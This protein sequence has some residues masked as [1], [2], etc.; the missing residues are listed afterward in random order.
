MRKALSSLPRALGRR[1]RTLNTGDARGQSLVELALTIPIILMLTLIALD[2]G[3]V[4]LG[5]INLQNMSRIAANFAANNPDAWGSVPDTDIQEHYANQIL[6]DAAATNCELPVSGG[7]PVVPA[8]TFT[9]TTSDGPDA[10]LGDTVTVRL[11]CTFGV[12]TPFIANV[13]GGS[14]SVGAESSFPVKAGMSAI[15]GGGSV[16]VGTAPNAAFKA[17]E[18][19]TPT[20]LEV[21][22]PEVDVEFRDT[23]GG[24]PTSWKWDFADGT[25]SNLQ[26]P[27][28][29]H[30][31]CAFASCSFVVK[32]KAS[33]LAGDSETSMTVT[34][35][36]DSDVNF[37]ADTQSGNAPLPVDFADASSPGGTAWAWDFGDGDSGT[38]TTPSHTY[39]AAGTYDVSLTVTYP[40]PIG[41]VT[42]TKTAFISVGS[43]VCTVPSLN[44]VR[45]N[46]ALAVWRGAP[47]NFTGSV[48]RDVGAPSGNFI[49]TAQDRTATSW[50]PCTSDVLVTRP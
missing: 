27:L 42:T 17:N 22:G 5:Y 1:A 31:S 32:M 38:G 23:S 47:Y 7:A 48:I 45:F 37:T 9:D 26:D 8:P 21:I 13:V 44:G 18:T 11:T 14:V 35:I 12:I 24:N 29:H 41:D 34:V 4:Y 50:E 20:A 3:R 43:G 40:A 25:T 39:T 19:I 28:G 16:P 46:D 30:F 49:I 36:G 2:F 6:A 10:V 15:A 33:N